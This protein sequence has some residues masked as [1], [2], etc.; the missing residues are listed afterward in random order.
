M[1][2]RKNSLSRITQR[3][4]AVPVSEEQYSIRRSGQ[5]HRQASLGAANTEEQANIR[6]Y[7]QSQRQSGL[8]VVQEKPS[9]QLQIH[10]SNVSIQSLKGL[11]NG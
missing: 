9:K 6:R 1:P 3:E 4:L 2:G 8:R 11:R 5:C 7:R 10:Q